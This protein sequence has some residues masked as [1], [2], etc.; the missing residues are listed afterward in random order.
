MNASEKNQL[1]EFA[2][3]QRVVKNMKTE[4][5]KSVIAPKSVGLEKQRTA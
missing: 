3:A 4:L 1:K 2:F 5:A